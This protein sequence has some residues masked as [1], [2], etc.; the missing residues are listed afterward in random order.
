M[1]YFRVIYV[2]HHRHDKEWIAMQ[3]ESIDSVLKN[4]KGGDIIDVRET[5]KEDYDDCQ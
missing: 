1:K 5:S 2:P 4:F 3:A